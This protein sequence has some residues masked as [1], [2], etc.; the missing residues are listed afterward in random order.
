MIKEI[1]CIRLKLN[2]KFWYC[3]YIIRNYK[4]IFKL[5]LENNSKNAKSCSNSNKLTVGI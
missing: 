1:V 5:R 3:L 4:L 2:I